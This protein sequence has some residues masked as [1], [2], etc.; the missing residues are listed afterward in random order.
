M[1]EASQKTGERF[2]SRRLAKAC[3]HGFDGLAG[4]HFA[5]IVTADPVGQGEEPA[6]AAHPGVA[7]GCNTADLIFVVIARSAGVGNLREIDV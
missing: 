5:A 7:V 3:E 2:A 1:D 6:V 4:C